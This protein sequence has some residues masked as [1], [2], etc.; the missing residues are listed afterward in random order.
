MKSDRR[1]SYEFFD[2]NDRFVASL[3]VNLCEFSVDRSHLCISISY[4]SLDVALACILYLPLMHRETHM[5]GGRGM[6]SFL[7][8]LTRRYV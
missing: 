5:D 3:L 8:N 4:H 7:R 6:K 2:C 1:T